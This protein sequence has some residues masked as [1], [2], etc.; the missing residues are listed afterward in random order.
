VRRSHLSN[1]IHFVKGFSVAQED[2]IAKEHGTKANG[3]R[4]YDSL[5]IILTLFTVLGVLLLAWGGYVFAKATAASD[6]NIEQDERLRV[7]ERWM[8][9]VE[10]KLD[11]ALEK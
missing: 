3:R 5:R 1:L 8:E 2:D 9:R 7:M 4:W 11:R 10:T 6:K